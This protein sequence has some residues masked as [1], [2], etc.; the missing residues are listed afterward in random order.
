M[1]IWLTFTAFISFNN[2][3]KWLDLFVLKNYSCSMSC[4]FRIPWSLGS[5]A[6]HVPT[7]I[8]KISPL[9]PPCMQSYAF[10]ST[11]LPLCVRTFYI[12]TPFPLINFYSDS[13]LHHSQFLGYFH[14]YLSLS[15]NFTFHFSLKPPS[16]LYAIA[17]IWIDPSPLPLCIRTMW[18]IPSVLKVPAQTILG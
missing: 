3:L 10:G 6:Q 11:P 4:F 2:G 16:F 17:C 15:L 7:I 1:L 18:M 14:F 12:F 13:S 5:S 9:L 8:T